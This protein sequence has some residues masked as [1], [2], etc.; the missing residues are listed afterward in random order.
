MKYFVNILWISIFLVFPV[1]AVHGE[2]AGESEKLASEIKS[3]WTKESCSS[4]ISEEPDFDLISIA[5]SGNFS[6]NE[7]RS[8]LDIIFRNGLFVKDESIQQKKAS[9]W[10]VYRVESEDKRRP[11][12]LKLYIRNAEKLYPDPKIKEQ[13]VAVLVSGISKPEDVQEWNV[14]G[15]PLIYLVNPW[16]EERSETLSKV[17]EYNQEFWLELKFSPEKPQA[18]EENEIN[19]QNIRDAEWLNSYMNSV[20]A[21]SQGVGG[22]YLKDVAFFSNDIFA[23]RT[24]LSTLRERGIIRIYVEKANRS[25]RETAE[26]M[27]M[28]LFEAD[29]FGRDVE[30][31]KKFS[32]EKRKAPFVLFIEAGNVPP[33]ENIRKKILEMDKSYYFI[34]NPEIN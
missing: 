18:Y 29:A 21:D 11:L 16:S 17:R 25:I 24:L 2:E 14:L 27:S 7:R 4:Y 12:Y 30:S 20:F 9:A 6:T 33:S 13:K 15:V 8:L 5:C 28:E 26:I 32:V 3:I 10:Y 23:L 19:R 1:F 34:S 31:G 22:V